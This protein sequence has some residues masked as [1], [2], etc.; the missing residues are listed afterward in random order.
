MAA[1]A[2]TVSL[3]NLLEHI[4]SY[5]ACHPIFLDN[6]QAQLE[7]LK[8]KVTFFENYLQNVHNIGGTKDVEHLERRIANASYEAEDIIESHIVD[9]ILSRSTDKG[10]S[11]GF[12]KHF[13]QK[14]HKAIVEMDSV[15]KR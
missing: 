1:Y 4:Q 12:I 9:D 3:L 13:S 2:A 8:V 15:R 10:K 11:I 5:H 6:Q 7:S 14:L